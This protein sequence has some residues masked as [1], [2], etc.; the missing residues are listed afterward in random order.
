[1]CRSRLIYS[2]HNNYS[3]RSKN[4]SL[5]DKILQLYRYHFPLEVQA[6]CDHWTKVKGQV[7]A[8]GI[9]Q[10]YK[11]PLCHE[12]LAKMAIRCNDCNQLILPGMPVML[13]A[14][15]ARRIQKGVKKY[16]GEIISCCRAGCSVYW[17]G[18]AGYWQAPGIFVPL[19]NS[20]ELRLSPRSKKPISDFL[21]PKE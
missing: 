17:N 15:D 8:Y 4:M 12:C 14:K 7:T 3:T 21:Y 11:L 1:M 13:H 18:M 20:I 6:Q 5:A 9:T 2:N 10:K 19:D 16:R